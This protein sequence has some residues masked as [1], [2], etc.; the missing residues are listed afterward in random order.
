MTN[1]DSL[2]GALG[3]KSESVHRIRLGQ[4]LVGKSTLGFAITIISI[5]VVAYK[6]NNEYLLFLIP[7]FVIGLFVWFFRSIKDFTEKNPELALLEG[8]N[9]LAWKQIE[10]AAKGVPKPEN[11]QLIENPNPNDLGL[12][13]KEIGE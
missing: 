6:T 3:I 11:Q 7:F 10:L 8:A 5:A 2:W 12:P 13:V 9:L 1:I 4:G